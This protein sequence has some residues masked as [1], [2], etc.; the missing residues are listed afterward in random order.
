MQYVQRKKGL[1]RQPTNQKKPPI[2]VLNL[3][4]LRK[5]PLDT[6]SLIVTA[7]IKRAEQSLPLGYSQLVQNA[8]QQGVAAV[9]VHEA[10]RLGIQLG[11]HGAGVGEAVRLLVHVRDGILL[12]LVLLGALLEDVGELQVARVLAD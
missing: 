3:H 5:I 1:K 7:V 11:Q 8:T 6:I 12:D 9:F 2:P 10:T 4:I